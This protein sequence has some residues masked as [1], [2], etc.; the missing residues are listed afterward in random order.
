MD[1]TIFDSILDLIFVIDGNGRVIYCNDTA[2]TFCQ[3]SVRR[4]SGKAMLHD[5]ITFAE[6]GLVP[7]NEDS[8]GR[9]VPTP[10]IETAYTL[11]K[12]GKE[13]KDGKVEFPAEIKDD[14]GEVMEMDVIEA[15][16]FKFL[17]NG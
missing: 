1:F 15:K 2:A 5:V 17:T 12:H 7:F 4:V 13:Y 9:K 3:T 10:F 8:Q 6:P 14:S 16:Y 11:P